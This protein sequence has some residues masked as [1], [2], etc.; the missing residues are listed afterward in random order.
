MAEFNAYLKF[1]GNCKEAMQFYKSC[2]GGSLNLMYVKDSPMAAKMG[3]EMGNLIM[4]S[5]LTN[6]SIMLMGS[7]MMGPDDYKQGNT[8]SLCLVC[9]TKEEIQTLFTNLSAGAKILHPLKEEFFGTYGDLVDKYGFSWM[10]QFSPNP[11]P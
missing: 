1:N 6:S 9:N 11:K 4:H 2:L 10:F 8:L 7:D 5:V 3:P